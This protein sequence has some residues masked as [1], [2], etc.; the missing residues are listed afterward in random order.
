MVEAEEER[1][2]EFLE[3]PGDLEEER[4]EKVGVFADLALASSCL[5]FQRGSGTELEEVVSR[6]TF[7]SMRDSKSAALLL[8]VVEDMMVEW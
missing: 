6:K 1:V 4:V 3:E 8:R 7:K 5:R 2:K